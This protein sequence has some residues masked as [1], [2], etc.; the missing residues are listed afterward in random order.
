MAT[1]T[2]YP[3]PH[4]ATTASDGYAA[5]FGVDETF[6]TIVG[7]SGNLSGFS[8]PDFFAIVT[9]SATTDQYREIDRI[10]FLFDTSPLGAGQ[11][12][13]SVTLSVWVIGKSANLVQVA[14]HICAS[15][16]ANNLAIGNCD[17]Q[18]MGA[19]SFGNIPYTSFDGTDSAYSTVTLNASGLAAINLTGITKF[20]ARVEWDLTGVFG[21]VWSSL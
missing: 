1:L 7:G 4:P 5:R 6:A 19:V 15:A 11:V 21:G 16:P 9:S 17:Y 8:D 12:V 18:T 20:G 14:L 13:T 10:A 3:Q 2:V